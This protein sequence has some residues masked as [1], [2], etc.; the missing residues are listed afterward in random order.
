MTGPTIGG[1]LLQLGG[2]PWIFWMNFIVG[3]AVS[4]AV[5][6][7]VKGSGEQ[8]KESFD[9]WGAL[10][11]LIG[12]PALLVGLTFGASNGWTSPLVIGCFL[13]R[14]SLLRV[15]YGSNYYL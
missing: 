12:Y 7:I 4:A 9:I 15:S 1:F 5:V 2:W 6:R 14:R 10:T 13:W 11:L 3:L 8:R